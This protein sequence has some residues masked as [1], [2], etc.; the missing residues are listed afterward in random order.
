MC[1]WWWIGLLCSVQLQAQSWI[2]DFRQADEARANG[3]YKEAV[4]LYSRVIA[5]TPDPTARMDCLN[6][7]A[8]CYKQL[9]D[10]RQA[11]ADYG[12]A[13]VLADTPELKNRILFNKT[14]VL[15]QTGR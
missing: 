1:K 10:Y 14:G 12:Q 4:A 9:A 7:R 2:A 15:L 13:E 8:G 11:L 5:A 3:L 6:S